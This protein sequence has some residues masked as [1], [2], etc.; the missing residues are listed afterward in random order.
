MLKR[1]L[2]LLRVLKSRRDFEQ[3]MTEEMRFHIEHYTDELVRSGLPRQDEAQRAR[4]EFGS[5]INV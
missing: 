5:L 2:S 3:H 4:I 1:F